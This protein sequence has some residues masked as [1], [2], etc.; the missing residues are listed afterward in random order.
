M[1]LKPKA[2]TWVPVQ[3][4]CVACTDCELPEDFILKVVALVDEENVTLRSVYFGVAVGTEE[5]NLATIGKAVNVTSAVVGVVLILF[6]LCALK[7]L[8]KVTH[9]TFAQ[10]WH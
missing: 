10:M 2:R 9:R 6:G 4:D 8:L 3:E 1:L 5:L 7:Y